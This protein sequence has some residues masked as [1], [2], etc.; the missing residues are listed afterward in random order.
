[1]RLAWPAV[2]EAKTM[3]IGTTATLGD[4]YS[5]IQAFAEVGGTHAYC[6]GVL[7]FMVTP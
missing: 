7:E 4:V 6:V 1:M 5:V 2:P 3:S